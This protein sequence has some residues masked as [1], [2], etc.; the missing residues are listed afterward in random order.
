M[1]IRLNFVSHDLI[2][3]KTYS[4]FDPKLRLN[5]FTCDGSDEYKKDCLKKQKQVAVDDNTECRFEM[6]FYKE[7]EVVLAEIYNIRVSQTSFTDLKVQ[8]AADGITLILFHQPDVFDVAVE[9]KIQVTYDNIGD[10]SVPDDFYFETL[11]DPKSTKKLFYSC[12]DSV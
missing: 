12:P 7:G 10:Y 2:V 3:Q 6:L 8:V 1:S 9:M 4:T 5:T 11:F